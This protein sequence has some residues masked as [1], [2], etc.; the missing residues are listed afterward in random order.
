MTQMVEQYMMFQ[1]K[2]LRL[3]NGINLQRES[4]LLK[5]VVTQKYLWE[6][7]LNKCLIN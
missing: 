3:L 1:K 7:S 2:E 5:R 4:F 6:K